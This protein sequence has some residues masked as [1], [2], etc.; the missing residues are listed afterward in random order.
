MIVSS[1]M[2]ICWLNWLWGS[3]KF[4]LGHDRLGCQEY[5]LSDQ[6]VKLGRTVNIIKVNLQDDTT[7]SAVVKRIIQTKKAPKA[8]GPYSQAVVADRTLYISGQL[9]LDPETMN[10]VA[11]GPEA[12][13]DQALKN[14]GAILEEAGATF[15]NVVKTT[16]LLQDI[17]DFAR[18]NEVYAKY[19]NQALPARA[20]YQVAALP[21]SGKVEIEAI[22]LLGELKIE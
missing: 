21:K 19:F 2:G 16:V 9:G 3:R 4:N 8:I 5:F 14:M 18:V 1:F 13:A 10:L 22:A 7:M 15:N 11:G 6:V 12:E 20:A 17:N